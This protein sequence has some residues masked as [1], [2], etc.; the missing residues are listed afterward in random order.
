MACTV[1]VS[2]REQWRAAWRAL[3]FACVVL[4]PYAIGRAAPTEVPEM[5]PLDV[6][7]VDRDFAQRAQDA[8]IRAAYDRYRAAD[9]S[10]S[11]P[12]PVAARDWL[13]THE[14]AT[15]CLEWVPA[16]AL[17][18]CDASLALTL[19]TWTYTAPDSRTSDTGQYLTA[20]R[21]GVEGGDWRIV[22]D[23][24]LSLAQLPTLSAPA[25][26]GCDEASSVAAD[27]QAA[28][29]KANGSLRNLHV[30]GQTKLS[31]RA[32][33][34]GTVTG[35][36]HA[37]LALTHGELLDRKAARGAQPQVRAV[38]VRIWQ[39]QGRAWRLLQDFTSVVTP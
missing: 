7:N 30:N 13:D 11:R 8:G 29:R 36:A 1:S 15:G 12:W 10:G 38:Y 33:M 34:T 22:L 2:D 35:S 26:A 16:T 23:Q 39:R 24:S 9:A 28:D 21:R 5:P 4:A 20:W 25:N 27:L 37:D 3:A 32:V 14:P 31:V 6:I 19:G 18:A 17:T